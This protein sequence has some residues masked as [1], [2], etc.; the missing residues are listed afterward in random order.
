MLVR[1]ATNSAQRIGELLGLPVVEQ[2]SLP[3]GTVVALVGAPSSEVPAG[4]LDSSEAEEFVPSAP[5]V[6]SSEATSVEQGVV[7]VN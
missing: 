7:C 2:R 6:Q 4:E 1:S 5:P 3:E